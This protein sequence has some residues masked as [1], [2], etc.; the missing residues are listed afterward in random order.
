MEKK[1]KDDN[2]NFQNSSNDNIIPTYLEVEYKFS[3]ESVSKRLRQV[4][5]DNLLHIIERL[6]LHFLYCQ[7]LPSV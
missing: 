7:L 4:P 3:F 5:K 2:C 1:N 6:C